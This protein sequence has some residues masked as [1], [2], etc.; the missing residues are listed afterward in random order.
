MIYFELNFKELLKKQEYK[1]AEQQFGYYNQHLREVMELNADISGGIGNQ[2]SYQFNLKNVL[3][4]INKPQNNETSAIYFPNKEDVKNSL[5]RKS[6]NGLVRN[7]EEYQ[8]R[9]FISDAIVDNK[10]RCCLDFNDSCDVKVLFPGGTNSKTALI[11][12]L[13]N[14]YR[15][16][17]KHNYTKPKNNI[18]NNDEVDC[19]SLSIRIDKTENEL[20]EKHYYKLIITES[21]TTSVDKFKRL[22]DIV[23]KNI[24][25][26]S[27]EVDSKAWGI[28]EIK[29]QA[30]YLIGL[31]IENLNDDK[32]IFRLRFPKKDWYNVKH[33]NDGKLEHN[34]YLKKEKKALV[35]VEDED[36]EKELNTCENNDKGLYYKYLN[37]LSDWHKGIDRD[38]E[39]II[40]HKNHQPLIPNEKKA[41]KSRNFKILI[42]DE[43][44]KK[45]GVASLNKGW[46][47][48]F[49]L[50]DADFNYFKKR[51]NSGEVLFGDS[52][53]LDVKEDNNKWEE[54]EYY[55]ALKDKY[56][57]DFEKKLCV[58]TRIAI[59]DERIQEYVCKNKNNNFNNED[60]FERDIFEKKGIV[61]PNLELLDLYNLFYPSE[62]ESNDTNSNNDF[63]EFNKLLCDYFYEEKMDY[64]VVHFSGLEAIANRLSDKEIKDMREQVSNHT[65]IAYD[66]LKKP[67]NI[68]VVYSYLVKCTL[69]LP[70]RNKYLILTSGK[71]TPK[72]L[73]N[74]SFFIN[75]NNIEHL[76]KSKNKTKLDFVKTLQSIRQI[77][78]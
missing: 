13:K 50:E 53:F 56:V 59:L 61:I 38:F 19:V 72:T 47:R 39:Y 14:I 20:L 8:V 65:G 12:I 45:E 60:V 78:N 31:A 11:Q 17:F 69:Q 73:P 28:K 15:N 24:L 64:V 40:F 4:S 43:L 23:K 18:L 37:N 70:K 7:K 46:V 51:V 76:V 49:Y 34:L 6:R 71:G 5:Y 52:H 21:V 2:T 44:F 33:N 67:A 22:K 66:E 16:I 41:Y 68:E 9:T 63:K 74:H 55:E 27:G 36:L 75:L 3:N 30:A 48:E 35:V 42:T 26:D 57:N 32:D 77:E 58:N 10:F 54:I 25:T 62:V 29:I 1:L